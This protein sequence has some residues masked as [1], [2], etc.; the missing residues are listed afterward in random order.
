MAKKIVKPKATEVLRTWHTLNAV[1]TSMDEEE[2]RH[3]LA[4]EQRHQGRTR[5]LRRIHSRINRVRAQR[6]RREIGG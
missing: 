3:L 1:L 4:M 6:E 2:C 5:F